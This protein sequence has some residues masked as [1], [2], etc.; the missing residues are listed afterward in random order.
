ME[1][2]EKKFLEIGKPFIHRDIKPD[3]IMVTQDKVVKVTDFG[4]VKIFMGLGKDINVDAMKDESTGAER[5][6]FS[7]VGN[8]CGT[9]PYMSPEQCSGKE[10]IDIRSDIYS[11]GCVLYEMLTGERPKDQLALII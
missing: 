8:I 9:P 5:C 7:V 1:H 4:L 3:N 10:D 11:F 6:G 2:A